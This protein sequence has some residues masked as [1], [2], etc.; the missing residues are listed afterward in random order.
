MK[1]RPILLGILKK[2]YSGRNFYCQFKGCLE[3]TCM[4]YSYYQCPISLFCLESAASPR[5]KKCNCGCTKIM[6]AHY[7]LAST[8]FYQGSVF[9]VDLR[10]D[11][12]RKRKKK[13]LKSM[14]RV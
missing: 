8:Y 14:G 10:I 6:T 4:C 12:K 7:H 5:D 11:E 1:S 13:K 9:K 2:V 3:I